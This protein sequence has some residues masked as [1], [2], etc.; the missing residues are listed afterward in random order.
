[1]IYW[2]TSAYVKVF[3][4]ETDSGAA[5]ELLRAS[6]SNLSSKLL[7]PELYSAVHKA[8]RSG[9]ATGRELEDILARIDE[10]LKSITL[11]SIDDEILQRAVGLVSRHAIRSGDSIHLAT[12]LLVRE[13]SMKQKVVFVTADAELAR[14]AKREGF[15]AK[16]LRR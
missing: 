4:C 6:K 13:E 3:V 10:G 14:A 1:M 9:N 11:C 12:G 2:D 5:R 8:R 16:R 7:V 15:F